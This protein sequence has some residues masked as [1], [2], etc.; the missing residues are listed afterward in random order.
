MITGSAAFSAAVAALRSPLA[1]ASSTLRTELR[2]TE[3][4]VLLIAVRRAILRVAL[5]ADVVLAIRSISFSTTRPLPAKPQK[6]HA[7]H[8]N[9]SGS[10]VAAKAAGYRETAYGRQRPAGQRFRRPAGPGSRHIHRLPRHGQ[11]L[12]TMRAAG[13]SAPAPDRHEC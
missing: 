9:G 2:S 10:S 3:R 8:G 1:I 7:D 13:S 5:R 11:R 12:E 4:R 6:K